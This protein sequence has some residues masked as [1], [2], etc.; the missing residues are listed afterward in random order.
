MAR[1]QRALV[2]QKKLWRPSVE[3]LCTIAELSNARAPLETIAKAVKLSP[4]G[5]R[6]WQDR[7][8]TAAA[9]EASNPAPLAP[10][11]PKPDKSPAERFDA[12]FR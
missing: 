8:K 4:R 2:M 6:A 5:F 3:Q 11:E 9:A 1:G 7:L 12:L 10:E